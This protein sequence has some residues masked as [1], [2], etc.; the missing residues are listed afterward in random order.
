MQVFTTY[1]ACSVSVH[2][3]ILQRVT[4]HVCSPLL[5][6]SEARRWDTLVG[7]SVAQA[8]ALD[9]EVVDGVV[10]CR[11]GGSLQVFGLA[12]A[13]LAPQQ[14]HSQVGDHELV[15]G[16]RPVRVHLPPGR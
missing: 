2:L 1:G 14:P 4:H 16:S 11:K 6:G 7:M 12:W 9:D 13:R 3:Q 5:T 10:V 8:A 15:L